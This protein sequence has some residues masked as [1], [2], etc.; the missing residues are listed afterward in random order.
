MMTLLA[1]SPAPAIDIPLDMS[2]IEGMMLASVRFAAFIVIAPPF[3]YKAFPGQVKAMVAVG[4]AIAVAPQ[5][6]ARMP[7]LSAADFIGSLVEQLLIGFALGFLVFLVF[8]AFVT[9]GGLIDLSSGFQ[10]SS[11]FNPALNINGAQ[12]ATLFQL[13]A[14]A[15]M[16][17]SGAY[18]VVLAGFSR[19]FASLPIGR[20][21]PASL[22]SIT[23]S[24]LATQ[25]TNMFV[26]ALQ[27]AGPLI[28]VLFL[29]DI[30]LGL[31]TKV[32][33]SLNA[34]QLSFP[35][36]ILLSLAL[37]GFVFMGLPAVV[38]NLTGT[39]QSLLVGGF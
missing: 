37:G 24:Q 23:G 22:L 38:E 14:T 25:T 34:F 36:K 33:P 15:L 29:C 1:A 11:A 28:V 32:A 31:L 6:T 5:V 35:L 39:A 3:A 10:M 2:W 18:Q 16:F 12:F 8:Q 30:G 21:L 17:T 27:I 7:Q 13:G 4:L 19:T 20:P 26:A 9:A